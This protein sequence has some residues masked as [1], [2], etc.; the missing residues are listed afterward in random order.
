MSEMMKI[1]EEEKHENF[2]SKDSKVMENIQKKIDRLNKKSEKLLR[3]SWRI[4]NIGRLS[5]EKLKT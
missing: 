5:R 4:Y 3:K 2:V 1:F